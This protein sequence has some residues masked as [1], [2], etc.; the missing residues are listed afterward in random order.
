ML[1]FVKRK[2]ALFIS[3]FYFL[4]DN[5]P[6]IYIINCNFKSILLQGVLMRFGFHISIAGGFSKVV[7]RAHVQGLQDHPIL[8]QKP[9][10]MEIFPSQ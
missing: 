5:K 10:G 3:I 9:E 6:R 4:I 1:V 2:I 7:E 8:L